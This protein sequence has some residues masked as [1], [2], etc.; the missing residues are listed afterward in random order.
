MNS[1]FKN[2]KYQSCFEEKGFVKVPLLNEEQVNEIV[3]FFNSTRQQHEIV[4]NLH[5]TTSHTEDVNLIKS[6]DT[7]IKSVLLPELNKI[8]L[9]FK[10]LVG[11]FQIKNPGTGS[12]TGIHQDP[13]FV[14]ESKYC[15]ANVWVALQ[16]VN[17]KN[18][19]LFFV[20]GSNH[21]VSSLRIA[22]SFPS[23]YESFRESLPEM[24]I[25]QPLKK[26]EAII[27][28]SA[29]IHGATENLSKLTR[30]AVTLLICSTSAQWLMY[31]KEEN[32]TVNKIEKYH[33]DLET[34]I[35][36]PNAGRPDKKK[37]IEYITF[38]FPQISKDEF[39]R[40]IE[41]PIQQNRNYLQRVK[42]F[43]LK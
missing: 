33:L 38:H 26:G 4:T 23:Y 12:N 16:D 42:D 43:L 40:K 17:E 19:N 34:F 37:I 29:T 27:F 11:V 25:H 1:I 28:N 13:T 3:D 2:E 5:Y 32:A 9:D 14:D 15:S 36:I 30:L 39:L 21:V 35:T 41:K 18:G 24:I 31:Y 20:S 7:K 8:L 10:P 6:T 22:P